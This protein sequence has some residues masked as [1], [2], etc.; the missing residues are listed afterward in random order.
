MPPADAWPLHEQVSPAASAAVAVLPPPPMAP[1]GAWPQDEQV[2][3]HRGG[4]AIELSLL[5]TVSMQG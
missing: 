3:V 1:A 2:N 4:I 5:H